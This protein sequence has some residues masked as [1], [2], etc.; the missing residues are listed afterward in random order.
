MK[1]I[2]PKISQLAI[3]CPKAKILKG[4]KVQINSLQI[5]KKIKKYKLGKSL[6]KMGTIFCLYLMEK[7]LQIYVPIYFILPVMPVY[8]RL[9]KMQV[10]LEELKLLPQI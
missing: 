1:L 8:E 4:I 5:L 3:F 10:S 2:K 6:T 7:V 9:E